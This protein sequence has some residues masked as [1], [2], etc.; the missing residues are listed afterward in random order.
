GAIDLIETGLSGHPGGEVS[1]EA[2]APAAMAFG[3]R[4]QAAAAIDSA[5]ALDPNRESAVW[6]GAVVARFQERSEDSIRLSRK[7]VELNPWQPHYRANLAQLLAMKQDWAGLKPQVEAWLQLDPASV[8]ARKT[9]VLYLIRTGNREQ[10]K[11]EFAK[12]ELLKPN[13][14]A[15]LRTE[16]RG[17]LN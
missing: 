2:K 7:A 5:L 15:E 17:W 13:N 6:Q 14:L 16:F 10:A 1:W 11:A 12:I 4:N 8:D 3:R 9:W